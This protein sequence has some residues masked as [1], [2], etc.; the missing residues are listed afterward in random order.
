MTSPKFSPIYKRVRH[1]LKSAR[2]GVVRS[3]NSAQVT[4]N[5]LIGQQIVEEEQKGKDQAQYGDRLIAALS[6]RLQKEFGHGYSA[7]SYTHLVC[8]PQM[9][10]Y[11]HIPVVYAGIIAHKL[12]C[13]HQTAKT[14]PRC[15]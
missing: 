10:V 12:V 7:V 1:I 9:P 8:F 5:W 13:S 4:A 6:S 2:A 3:V 15:V 11:L 14:I